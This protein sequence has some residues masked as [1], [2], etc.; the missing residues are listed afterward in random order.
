MRGRAVAK[1]FGGVSSNMLVTSFSGD[2]AKFTSQQKKIIGTQ[3]P[4]AVTL[5]TTTLAKELK[6]FGTQEIAR[7]YDR[8]TGWTKNSLFY[9]PAQKRDYPNVFAEVYF[10][11]HAPKGNPAGKYL[12]PTIV[13]R[14]RTHKRFE[15]ALIA[16]GLMR[17]NEFAVPAKGARLNA[18]GN[19]TSGVIIKMLSQLGAAEMTAGHTANE[20]LRSKQRK[21]SKTG[22]LTGARYFIPLDGSALPRG[23]YQRTGRGQP[24]MLFVFVTDSPDYSAVLPFIKVMDT[25][26]KR[27]S[28]R[29]WRETF[30]KVIA[31]DRKRGRRR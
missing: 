2:D 30:Y 19:I 18:S 28:P 3:M 8:P 27:I 4:Y 26:A 5:A 31:T 22:K 21:R 24:K 23:V 6:G 7:R 11:D 29:I 20:T 9:K 12:H 16:R 17:S 25:E 1:F 15:K 13:G 14:A 10:K